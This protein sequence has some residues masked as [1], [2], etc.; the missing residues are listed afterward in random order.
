VIV[1][2]ALAGKPPFLAATPTDLVIAILHGKVA[3]LRSLRPDVSQSV[4]AVVMRAMAVAVTRLA[5]TIGA[6]R[7]EAEPRGVAGGRV[8]TSA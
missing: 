8:A 3:P 5:A 1:Y 6:A 7:G 4:E 2:E